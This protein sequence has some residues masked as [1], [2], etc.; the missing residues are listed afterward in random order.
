MILEIKE[1][2]ETKEPFIEIPEDICEQLDFKVGD[3]ILW[4]D[5][6][7]GSY[8]LTKKNES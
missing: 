1:D 6:K 3:T 2:P 4:T 8:T 7:D 5:N